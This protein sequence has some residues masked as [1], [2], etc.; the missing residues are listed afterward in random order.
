RPPSERGVARI[1]FKQLQHADNVSAKFRSSRDPDKDRMLLQINPV[2]RLV[3]AR[4]NQLQATAGPQLLPHK[5][6]SLDLMAPCTSFG[7]WA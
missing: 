3:V 6:Y 5:L 7:W 2:A 4:T 1:P